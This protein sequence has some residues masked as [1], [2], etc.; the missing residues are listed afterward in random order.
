[1]KYKVIIV[2]DEEPARD[3]LHSYSQKIEE[4]ET[5]RRWRKL[6]QSKLFRTY[7]FSEQESHLRHWVLAYQKTA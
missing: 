6:D 5:A 3:L 2:D 7:P 1:M 4:L